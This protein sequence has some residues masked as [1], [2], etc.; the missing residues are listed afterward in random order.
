VAVVIDANL[1][2]RFTDAQYDWP[3]ETLVNRQRRPA[4]R[5]AAL[6]RA[7]IDFSRI[8]LPP[9]LAE[10]EELVIWLEGHDLKDE[11]PSNE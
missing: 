7:V 11:G 9:L 5:L 3:V 8:A 2:A 4:R 1:H 10:L 6:L